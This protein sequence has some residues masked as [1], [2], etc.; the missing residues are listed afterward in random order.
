MLLCDLDRI[1]DVIEVAVGAE[2]DIDFLDVL[3][4]LRTNGIAHDP[5]IDQDG[6]ARGSFERKVA[7]P[8]QVSLMPFRFMVKGS[9]LAIGIWPYARAARV[10]A[11]C[12]RANC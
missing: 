10:P 8:S 7:W 3:L 11:K 4:R 9:Q 1:A 12:Q 5:G 2:H 6:L